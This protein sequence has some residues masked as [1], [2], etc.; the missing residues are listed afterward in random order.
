MPVLLRVRRAVCIAAL[1]G[2][3]A[4]VQAQEAGEAP[5]LY[6]TV[7]Q[8]LLDGLQ[9]VGGTILIN[10]PDSYCAAASA[11]FDFTWIEMQHS[12]LTYQ[13]AARMIAA[14]AGAPAIPFIRIAAATE[15]DIQKATDIGALGI[16]VPLVDSVET[17]TDAVRFAKYPP[18]GRRS[19]GSG[20]YRALWGDDYRETANDNIM[21]IAMIENPAG[22]ALADQIAAVPGV[23]ALFV[24]STDPG[25]FSGF[26]QGQAEYEALV[27]QVVAAA[28]RAGV[29]LGGP[30]AWRATRGEY[31]FFQG[32]SEA[33]L[34]R[35]GALGA[36]GVAPAVDR[37]SGVAPIEGAEP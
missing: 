26:R 10:N 7:K 27:D 28:D 36:L 30:S 8:K 20:Q 33:A 24:A 6:N 31:S 23:D 11:G 25:S 34:L 14:C 9:V 35:T 29:F 13:D 19:Q 22:A 17:I 15:D 21:V 37:F 4:L 3:A 1:V 12:P 16:I 2:A 18:L 32:P 5:R